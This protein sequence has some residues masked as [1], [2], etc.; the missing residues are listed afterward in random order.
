MRWLRSLTAWERRQAAAVLEAFV[1]PGGPGLSPHP[2]EEPDYAATFE[3]AVRAACGRGALGFRLAL[4]TAALYPGFAMRRFRTMAG[5]SRGERTRW[6]LA[7]SRHANPTV[8]DFVL[9]LKVSASFALLAEPRLRQRALASERGLLVP[10]MPLEGSGER[11]LGEGLLGPERDA[12]EGP[13][14]R[15]VS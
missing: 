1:A 14:R 5:L 6:L 2:G 13:S 7:L 4:L 12:M 10:R 15:K 3:R 11:P 8:R 9:L